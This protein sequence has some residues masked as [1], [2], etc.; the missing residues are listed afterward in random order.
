MNKTFGIVWSD[1]SEINTCAIL[2]SDFTNDCVFYE[3]SERLAFTFLD[4]FTFAHI[5]VA[6]CGFCSDA[7]IFE[8]GF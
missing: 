6:Y 2:K 3:K 4:L 5:T 7:M 1:I 8:G